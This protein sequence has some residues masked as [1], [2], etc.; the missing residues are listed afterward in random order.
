MSSDYLKPAELIADAVAA[1][2]RKA[3]LPVRDLLLRGALAGGFLGYATSLVFVVLS[4]GVPPIVGAI[5]FPVGFVLL[6]LLGLE[7]V[8]GNFAL[9]PA[10]VM[11]GTVRVTKLLRNWGWVYLGNLL[12]SVLYAALF[13]LAITNWRTGNGGAVAD[14]LKQAAQKKTLA[15]VALGYSGWATAIVKAVLCNW[16]V[17]IGAVLAMVSRSTVGKITAMWLPI[18]TFFAL[19]FEHSVVNM[20]LIP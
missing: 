15:Y 7:L 14:L 3:A 9:L 5:L 10:G 4:Q 1:A 16:M 18:M 8:T 6:V 13:Y 12:G 17:T 19:G 20:Y 11:A 2:E